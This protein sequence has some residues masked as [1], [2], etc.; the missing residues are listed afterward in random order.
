MTNEAGRQ[1]DA[2]EL[3]SDE[4]WGSVTLGSLFG[5]DIHFWCGEI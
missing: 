4:W 5:E 2:W 1:M 3:R